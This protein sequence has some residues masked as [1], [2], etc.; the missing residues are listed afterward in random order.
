MRYSQLR[1]TFMNNAI[2]AKDSLQDLMIL[3]I[4]NQDGACKNEHHYLPRHSQRAKGATVARTSLVGYAPPVPLG[5]RAQNSSVTSCDSQLRSFRIVVTRKELVRFQQQFSWSPSSGH[6]R[7]NSVFT[8]THP[9]ALI[10][11][12]EDQSSN[13]LRHDAL[14]AFNI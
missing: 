8:A 10:L 4:N 7:H 3:F 14:D 6:V 9:P 5:S 12:C 1:V 11:R 13:C 2:A